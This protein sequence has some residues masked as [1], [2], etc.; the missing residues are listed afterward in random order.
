MLT[1][2]QRVFAL[3]AGLTGM[4]LL[5]TSAA[6]QHVRDL[7]PG[8][9]VRIRAAGAERPYEGRLVSLSRDSLVLA[10]AG[11]GDSRVA[12]PRESVARAWIATSQHRETLAGLGIG[13]LAGAAVGAALGALAYQP[14][15]GDFC[16]LDFGRG[17][18]AAMAGVLLGGVGLVLGGI[19]GYCTHG[20]NWEP[21]LLP[22]TTVSRTP[23][24][25]GV[26]LAVRVRL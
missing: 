3:L 21:A 7:Q 4:F 1:H 2:S 19:A 25:H 12:L 14:C 9:T 17:G 10:L 23:A 18:E 22:L 24:G 11:E 5:A 8:A 13:F 26:A 6:A 15:T 20:Q 16:I